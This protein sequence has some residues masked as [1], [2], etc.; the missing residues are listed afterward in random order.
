LAPI[1]QTPAQAHPLPGTADL[2]E[3][4][5]LAPRTEVA[6][7]SGRP[8]DDVRRFVD[9][10][11]IYYIG[12]HGLELLRPGIER[13]M[14]PSAAVIRSL[15]PTLRRQLEQ[16]IGS[17]PGI[18]LE[19][20]GAAIACHYRLAARDDAQRARDAVI[21]LARSY[22]RRGVSLTFID[23][24][25]VTEIRPIDA[26]KG[27]AVCALLSSRSPAPLAL[28]I[29]DDRT[30]EDAFRQ[31]PSSAITVRVAGPSEET[32]ARYRVSDPAEVQAFLTDVVA[33]RS[34]G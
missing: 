13:Q 32:A 12:I 33:A 4:L 10:A 1:A 31:L 22:Q 14:S 21:A 15:M 28:Y 5:S 2:I 20:K 19:E 17:R 23:G 25:E 29:G 18:L 9:V 26:N 24:H 8:I 27:K 16:Q 34:R 3:R 30:D 6:I 7:V 11:G